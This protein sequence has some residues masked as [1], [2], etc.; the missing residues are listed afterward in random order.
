MTFNSLHCTFHDHESFKNK[1]TSHKI[2]EN[3]ECL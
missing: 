1:G 2:E 3:D